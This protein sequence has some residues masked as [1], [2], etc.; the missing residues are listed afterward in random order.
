M[1]EVSIRAV[2]VFF[3]LFL[4]SCA[5]H[6]CLPQM[7]SPFAALSCFNKRCQ[8]LSK[9]IRKQKIN[10]FC[11][12]CK[13]HGEG[14]GRNGGGGG[15]DYGGVVTRQKEEKVYRIPEV[16]VAAN[17]QVWHASHILGSNTATDA[18]LTSL[19]LIFLL[20]TWKEAS[21]LLTGE[22]DKRGEEGSFSACVRMI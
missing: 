17:G 20:R 9:N 7:F 8:Q 2:K 4:L 13:S 14:K 12:S 1:V 3:Y 15:A 19:Q 11:Y 5:L 10:L 21:S 16:I 6:C 18:P 22:S